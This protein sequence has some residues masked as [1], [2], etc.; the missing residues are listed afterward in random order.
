MIKKFHV[1]D[2]LTNSRLPFHLMTPPRTICRISA[3]IVLLGVLGC[4]EAK[5]VEVAEVPAPKVENESVI[6]QPSAPQLT[7]LAVEPVTPRNL[8]VTH[9]TGRLYWNDEKT[10]RIF[11]PVAGRVTAILADLGA[12]IL[13][14]TALAEIDSPDYAAA[15]ANARTAVGNL[16]AADRAFTRT[17]ALLAH[18]AFAQKDVDAAEAAYVSALAERDR[19]AGVLANYGGRERINSELQRAESDDRTEASAAGYGGV[20]TPTNVHSHF[21]LRS[22]IVGE[23]VERNINPGQEIRPD[24]MLASFQPVISP[25]FVVSDPTKL[26]VQVDVA[27]GDLPALEAGLAL[28]IT[29]KAFP[30]KVFDGVIDKIG[31]SMDPFTRTVKVRGTVNNPDRL[32]R[33]EMYVVADVVRS[34]AQTPTAGVNVPARALFMKNGDSYLFVEESP[35]RYKRVKVNVGVE[36]DDIVPVFQGLNPGQKVVTE[37]ALLLQSVLEPAS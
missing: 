4:K 5:P 15:L 1:I 36:K 10:V 32:L 12:P 22:R 27:E 20:V 26:W 33:A 23:L 8:A 3:W 9:A 6:F 13:D 37:G 29:C 7:A 18:G 11:T 19:A 34:L 31:Q 28:R 17:K 30:G 14:G 25:L 2:R 24:M 21:V 16:M 35:G